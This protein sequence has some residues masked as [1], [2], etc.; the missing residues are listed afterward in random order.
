MANKKKVGQPEKELEARWWWRRLA[1]CDV[2]PLEH[3]T[4]FTKKLTLEWELK[5][6]QALRYEFSSWE[7]RIEVAAW[8]YELVRRIQPK[9]ELPSWIELPSFTHGFLV[10][11]IGQ[12]LAVCPARIPITPQQQEP[13]WSEP[14]GPC[15]CDLR[16]DDTTLCRWF[17]SWVNNQREKQGLPVT[18][19]PKLSGK[20]R[21][22]NVGNR[23]RKVSWRWPELMDIHQLGNRALNNS[24]RP[25]KTNAKREAEAWAEKALGALKSSRLPQFAYLLRHEPNKQFTRWLLENFVKEFPKARESSRE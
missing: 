6:G 1:F 4:D 8:R 10:P 24:E 3:T 25:L 18:L 13:G 15:Q 17:L 2:S 7:K 20:R 19:F 9:V 12:N 14:M 11:A 16:L 22:Y 5:F 23:N 21:S